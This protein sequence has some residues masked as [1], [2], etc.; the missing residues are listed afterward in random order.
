MHYVKLKEPK[1]LEVLP[2]LGQTFPAMKGWSAHVRFMS[3]LFIVELAKAVP[4][5]ESLGAQYLA[6]HMNGK[7]ASPKQFAKELDR[8]AETDSIAQAA[9]RN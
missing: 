2:K 4:P 9:L 6:L 1:L 5:L 7:K 3:H 8:I